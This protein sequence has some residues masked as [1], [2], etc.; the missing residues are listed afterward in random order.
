MGVTAHWMESYSTPDG[1]K[2]IPEMLPED[3]GT[4]LVKIKV[5]GSISRQSSTFPKIFIF[6]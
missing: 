2:T 3:V 6:H 4:F 1:S 5:E